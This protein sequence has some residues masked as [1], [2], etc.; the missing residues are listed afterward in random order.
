MARKYVGPIFQNLAISLNAAGQQKAGSKSA[1]ERQ[2]EKRNAL[3]IGA[4]DP[5]A[6]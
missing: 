1:V 5:F 2:P 3:Q 6:T 4:N